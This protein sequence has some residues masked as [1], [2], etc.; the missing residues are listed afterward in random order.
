MKSEYLFSNLPPAHSYVPG[1]RDEHR[2]ES[3]RSA[4]DFA[5]ALLDAKCRLTQNTLKRLIPNV[6]FPIFFFL[7]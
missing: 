6:F 5:L 2:G 7:F 3:W 1:K 4:R